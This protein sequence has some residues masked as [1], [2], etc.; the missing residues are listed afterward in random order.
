MA[1]HLVRR[2]GPQREALVRERTGL[3]HTFRYLHVVAQ[4][5]DAGRPERCILTTRE[6]SSDAWVHLCVS[7]SFSRRL[8]AELKEGEAVAAKGRVATIETN[9]MPPTITVDP[10]VLLHRDRPRP[11]AGLELLHEVDSRAH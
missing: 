10:A 9:V 4:T 1:L 2:R 11:K 6:P 8:A 3:L 5:N 7:G